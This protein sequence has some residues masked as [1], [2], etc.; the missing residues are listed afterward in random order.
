MVCV[1]VSVRLSLSHLICIMEYN[2][3]AS[4]EKAV[5]EKAAADAEVFIFKIFETKL[6]HAHTYLVR[7]Y[8]QHDSHATAYVTLFL[9]II[10]ARNRQQWRSTAR[11]PAV[12]SYSRKARPFLEEMSSTA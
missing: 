7:M 8:S 3:R 2:I 6:L 4:S 10:H 5:P 9:D 12:R 11:A 1:C